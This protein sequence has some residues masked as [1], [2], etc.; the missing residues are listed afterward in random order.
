M[1]LERRS[2]VIPVQTTL[3]RLSLLASELLALDFME[4][5]LSYTSNPTRDSALSGIFVVDHNL[6]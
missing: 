5:I 1:R 6:V 2:E 3:E 4:S